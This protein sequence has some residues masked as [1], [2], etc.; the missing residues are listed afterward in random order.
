VKGLFSSRTD[1]L[2]RELQNIPDLE[3]WKSIFRQVK[4]SKFLNS[5]E[6]KWKTTLEW[7]MEHH[8]EIFE[9]K[10]DDEDKKAGVIATVQLR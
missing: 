4:N 1:L 9:G 7:V 10:Y 5:K 3:Y 8:T 6:K 2:V